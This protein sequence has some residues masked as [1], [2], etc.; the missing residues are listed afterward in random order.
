MNIEE[1]T[2]VRKKLDG[3]SQVVSRLL[4]IKTFGTSVSHSD[5]IDNEKQLF[6]LTGYREQVNSEELKR[7]EKHLLLAKAWGG[8]MLKILNGRK[9]PYVASYSAVVARDI[10]APQDR[11]DVQAWE[12]RN[13]WKDINH[14]QRVVFLRKSFEEIKEIVSGWFPPTTEEHKMSVEDGRDLDIARS[15]MHNH[16][17]EARFCLGY[18]LQRIK[19]ED[20]KP[21]KD[22]DRMLYGGIKQRV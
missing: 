18:E 12:K 10:V 21:E 6:E 14:I 15:N 4:P 1:I 9:S 16:I 11:V 2:V 8:E 13:N 22:I 5:F 3:F 7:T 19:E 20:S 17:T